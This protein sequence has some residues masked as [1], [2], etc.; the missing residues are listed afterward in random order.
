[1]NTAHAVIGHAVLVPVVFA[2]LVGV[3][4]AVLHL[5]VAGRGRLSDP[6]NANLVRRWN[7]QA[8]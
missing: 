3:A 6:L 5:D 7:A 4:Y 1:M 8:H 2:L